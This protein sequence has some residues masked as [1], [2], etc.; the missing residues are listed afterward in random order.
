MSERTINFYCDEQGS[1]KTYQIRLASEGDGWRVLTQWGPRGGRQSQG[2]KTPGGPVPLAQAEKV[3]EKE[4][5]ARLAKGYRITDA[6]VPVLVG[7]NAKVDSGLR[8]QLLNPIERDQIEPYLLDDSWIGQVKFD[9]ERVMVRATRTCVEGINRKG[10][11]RPLPLEL[12]TVIQDLPLGDRPTVIDGELIG[13]YYCAFD[14]L[15]HD[16][17]D[18]C[19][20]TTLQRHAR[21]S[22]L[23]GPAPN[24]IHLAR[25]AESTQEKRAMLARAEADGE[26]G[27]VLKRKTAPYTPGRPN[28]GGDALKAKF[29]ETASCRVAAVHGDRRS[30]ALEVIDGTGA[31]IGVGNCTVPPNQPVPAQAA[32]VEVRYL[33]FTG[34]G[35]S[36]VQP[37]LLH[38]RT[39]ID[40]AECHLNQLKFKMQGRAAA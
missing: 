35:G 22:A 3:M 27:M 4:I 21:L 34:L 33:Y 11:V 36:L 2:D 24:P 39:D 10:Q 29:C 23:I 18:L 30:I 15:M 26:E 8:P 31:W 32:I 12:V 9:G 25:C 7:E 37:V 19:A 40:A 16:G 14:L 1:D 13:T 38:A 6:D 17:E 5:K 20:Q 28:S